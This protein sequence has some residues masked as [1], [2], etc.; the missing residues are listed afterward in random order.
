M[1]RHPLFDE[2]A[3]KAAGEILAARLPFKPSVAVVLGSGLSG[4]FSGLEILAEIPFSEVA[5]LPAPGVEGH[6]G[7]FVLAKTKTTTALF[8]AGRVHLYEGWS[9]FEVALAVAAMEEA[10]AKSLVLTNAA[11]GIHEDLAPGMVM[12]VADHINLQAASPMEG[13]PGSARFVSMSD[14]WDKPWRDAV[15]KASKIPEGVYVAVRG[16]QYETP[17]EIR[18]FRSLGADAVGMSTAAEAIMARYLGMKILG[19]SLISN[20]AAGL[21]GGALYHKEVVE[22]GLEAGEHF[23]D[24]LLKAIE[25]A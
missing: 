3:I 19:L 18:A 24:I 22:T 9:A 7:K 5:N 4:A 12:A 17:A 14:A 20:Y 8:A 13:H 16:P 10:G 1:K 15:R 25:L 23:R 6:G 11:G 2:T 21:S